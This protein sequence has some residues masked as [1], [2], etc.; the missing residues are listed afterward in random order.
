MNSSTETDSSAVADSSA[1]A[2]SS[3]DWHHHPPF[4]PQVDSPS[5]HNVHRL[6][7]VRLKLPEDYGAETAACGQFALTTHNDESYGVRVNLPED[8]RAETAL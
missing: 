8:C 7:V 3:S 6:W 5:P 4:S 2:T 1:E